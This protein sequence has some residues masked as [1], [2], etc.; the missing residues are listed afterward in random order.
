MVYF[1]QGIHLPENTLNSENSSQ[2]SNIPLPFEDEETFLL[3]APSTETGMAELVVYYFDDCFRYDADNNLWYTWKEDHWVKDRKELDATIVALARRKRD[4]ARLSFSDLGKVA[5]VSRFT[6]SC[7]NDRRIRDVISRCTKQPVFSKEAPDFDADGFLAGVPK[8]TLDLRKVEFRKPDP[9]DLIT[10]QLGTNYDPQATCPR[11]LQFLGEVFPDDSELIAYIQQMVGYSLTGATSEQAI[12]ILLGSGANGKSVFLSTLQAL[13]GDYAGSTS[14]ATFDSEGSHSSHD[15]PLARLKGKRAVITIETNDDNR[16]NEARIKAMTGGSDLMK[17]SFKFG[18]EFEFQPQFKIWLATNHRPIIRDH[19]K[20][21]WRRLRPIEFKQS[22][23]GERAD[24]D[25]ADKLKAELPGILNWAL[26]G[27]KAWNTSREDQKAIELPRSVKD[28][29]SQWST[30]EDWLAQWL[31]ERTEQ[32]SKLNMGSTEGFKD[33]LAWAG[34]RNEGRRIT[35]TSWGR[36]MKD[37]GFTT[38]RMAWDG[39]LQTV[40]PGMKLLPRDEALQAQIDKE[41]EMAEW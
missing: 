21:M 38:T 36:R 39:K 27:L 14:F 3:E 16:F 19:S 34:L 8:G 37:K 40:Y 18:H 6:K 7:E 33:F 24:P 9:N 25:L 13:L 32:N 17:A 23:D 22:F 11:W 12:F 30:D 4:L 31:E 1:E 20:G 10:Y 41:M 15:E 35:Q 29:L 2:R 5:E 26:E 28:Y